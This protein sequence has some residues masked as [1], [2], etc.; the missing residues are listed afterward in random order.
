ME[1]AT[2]QRLRCQPVMAAAG[3]SSTL[4]FLRSGPA[5]AGIDVVPT[6]SSVVEFRELALD[7][8]R[9]AQTSP[10]PVGIS[11]VLR[12]DDQE[13]HRCMDDP[14]VER[15]AD[16]EARVAKLEA[17]LSAFRGVPVGTAVPQPP[18]PRIDQRIVSGPI[19][20]PEPTVAPRRPAVVWEA[21][22]ILKWVGIGLVVLAVGFALS[23]A[24]SRGWIGPELQ[25]AGAVAFSASLI[26]AGLRLHATRPAWTHALCS[27]GLLALFTTFA[28]NLFLD[29]ASTSVAYG[30]TLATAGSGIVLA[31]R[32][33][34]QWVLSATA[35]G[36]IVA[37]AVIGEGEPPVAVSAAI[38]VTGVAAVLFVA[39][40]RQWYAV[41][42]TAHAALLLSTV[43][44]AAIA[45]ST[46]DQIAVLVAGLLAL[47][48]LSW[49]P[50]RGSLE[51]VFHQLEVQLSTSLGAFGIAV[52]GLSFELDGDTTLGIIGL[53]VGAA[54]GSVAFGLRPRLLEAH[55]VSL[56]IAASVAV[57][58]G[59]AFLLSTTAAFVAVAIQGAGLVVLSQKLEREIRVLLNGFVLLAISAS[60]VA[61]ATIEGWRQDA[62]AGDDL[63]HLIIV[64]ALAVAAWVFWDPTVRRL[65]GAVVLAL[66]LSWLGS[67]LVHLPQGQALVSVSWAV[68]GVAVLAAGA[69]QK[70]PELGLAGLAVLALTV[71]KL[72]TVD[73]TEVDTLWRAGLFLVVGLGLMRLGFMLPDLTGRGGPGRPD[74]SHRP[75]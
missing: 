9:P 57:S 8:P 32:V 5:R 44:L 6:A 58:I 30:L 69:I 19:R 66:T 73:L 54:L 28:S 68:V 60:F 11:T 59:F 49:L 37:W 63:G 35:V 3:S 71:G 13:H 4:G 23:T 12:L 42:L 15:L 16:L 72:L 18:P 52:I 75:V 33:R 53:G 47:A 50:S 10:P 22:T 46:A 27:G 7:G 38:L 17:E 67:V 61:Q 40:R 64:G 70:L 43:L 74:R 56:L 31:V 24:I 25:L 26:G 55:L 45:E 2:R 21:E 14:P 20:T 51:S 1:H 62:A 39:E 48:S 41:R 65:G 29:Q 34:S 36:S